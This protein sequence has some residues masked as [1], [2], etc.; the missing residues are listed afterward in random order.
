MY[1]TLTFE[2]PA[3]FY[4]IIQRN[5]GI[6]CLF[7]SGSGANF[8]ENSLF[9][10]TINAG[11]FLCGCIWLSDNRP[12][13]H[14]YMFYIWNILIHF[15]ISYYYF[16]NWVDKYWVG[17][18]KHLTGSV[19]KCTECPQDSLYHLKWIELWLNTLERKSV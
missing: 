18:F 7:C 13:S 6:F 2:T 3:V 10:A 17:M 5:E 14:L 1:N 8:P 4:F 15:Q 12:I 16:H 9:T 11:S 19:I